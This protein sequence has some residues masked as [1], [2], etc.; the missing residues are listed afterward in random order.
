MSQLSFFADVSDLILAG[1]GL[2]LGTLLLIWWRQQSERWYS[3]F[4][5]TLLA[6]ALM[7]LATFSL[8][9]V[10]PHNVGC[11]DG[12]A[13]HMGYPLPF[14]IIGLN[15][16]ISLFLL[17]FVL[18]LLLIWLLLFVLT[19]IARFVAEAVDLASRS[20]RFKVGF[21][22]IVFIL[23]LALLPRYFNPPEPPVFGD[24]LRLSVNARRAAETTYNVTGFW[25]Q[26]LALEDIRYPP[27]QVPDTF[28]G[29]D[30]PQSQICLRGYT[31][32]YI[33]WMRYRVTL[34]RPGVTP[35]NMT[36]V[37]LTGSCWQN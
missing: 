14:A 29:I 10:P 22:V 34:D 23:P 21:F 36:R 3:V 25:I 26:R 4:A 15:G 28:G 9:V 7:D 18:N 11:P 37:P 1:A 31:Y 12:C 24:E 16:E 20:R 6:A 8:F 17:D 5:L 19:A 2:L 32:F 33:P 30:R 13:G 27:I 35:L